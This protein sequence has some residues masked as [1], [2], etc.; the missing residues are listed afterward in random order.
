R[1]E[2]EALAIEL[3][4]SPQKIVDVKLK[5]ANNRLT[6]PLFDTQRFTKNLETAYMKM[7]ER[8]QSD[9]APEHI[10]IPT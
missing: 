3:A 7:F 4:M 10:T 6:T 9:L 5:L 8:Y 1:Q 2:Y